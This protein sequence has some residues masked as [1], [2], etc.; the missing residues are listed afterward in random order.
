VE[1]SGK[2][3]YRAYC[4]SSDDENYFPWKINGRK[5]EGSTTVEVNNVFIISFVHSSCYVN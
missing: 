5:Q 2:K 3:I 1:N 4:K